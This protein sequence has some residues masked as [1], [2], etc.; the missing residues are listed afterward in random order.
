VYADLLP[1]QHAGHDPVAQRIEELR[2]RAAWSRIRYFTPRRRLQAARETRSLR[3]DKVA[4]VV[5][6]EAFAITRSEPGLAAEWATFGIQ[7]VEL[8]PTKELADPQRCARLG[9]AYTVLGN[10]RRVSNDYQGATAAIQAA[11]AHLENRWD[12]HLADLY[13]IHASLADDLGNFEGAVELVEKGIEIYTAL[14]N[15]Y[16]IARL[17]VKHAN[18]L[19]EVQP[20]EA[21]V[22]AADALLVLPQTEFR[23]AMLAHCI[24]SQ[25]LAEAGDG[26]AALAQL[27]ETRPLINQFREPWLDYRVQ[28]LEALVLEKVGHIADAERLY[29]E[30]A[31]LNWYREMYRESFMVRLRLFEFYLRRQRVKEATEVCRKAVVHLGEIRIHEQMK[32]VWQRLFEAAEAQA[33]KIEVLP[34]I[35]DYMVRHWTVPAEH[36]PAI[37][38]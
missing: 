1:S 31:R 4:G 34:K 6:S 17:K 35:R 25:A 11:Y 8:L 26:K 21:R 38:A 10:A 20:A 29:A 9:E 24:I 19:R 13:S 5:L 27:E 18:I 3:T 37:A 36:P 23:L 33:L 16:G 15:R 7:L 14:R 22:I 12:A 2:A 28:F 32:E 30:V